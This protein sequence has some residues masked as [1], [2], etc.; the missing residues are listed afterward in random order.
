MTNYINGSRIKRYE[1]PLTEEML[2][3]LHAAKSRKQ[4]AADLRRQAKEEAQARVE[5]MKQRRA[6]RIMTLSA[7]EELSENYVEPFRI[8]VTI[9]TE[10]TNISLPAFID[11][12][13]DLNVLS[14][15]TWVQLGKPS[16]IPADITFKNF[17]KSETP[18]LGSCYLKFRVQDQ[19]IYTLFYVTN[20]NQAMENIV[21]GRY[22]TRIG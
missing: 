10:K 19:P 6:A 13:A 22:W 14:F 16:L 3:R 5:K 20:K 11:S 8:P 17:S 15:E 2:D 12:G 18:C 9:E 4:G 7:G 1:E 21:L